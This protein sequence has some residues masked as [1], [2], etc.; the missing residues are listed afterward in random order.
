[1]ATNLTT[2]QI[3]NWGDSVKTDLTALIN[4]IKALPGTLQNI[5]TV[6]TSD[7]DKSMY[8]RYKD[9]EELMTTAASKLQ[10]FQSAF[11][12]YLTTYST[13]VDE[14]TQ[15]QIEEASKLS[16]YTGQDSFAEIA[17]IIKALT[18]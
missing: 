5:Q 2:T 11:V 1:M 16:D 7:D 6:V 12:T 9:L 10:E 14:A 13:T 3:N 17:A 15:K 18:L 8:L 4:A